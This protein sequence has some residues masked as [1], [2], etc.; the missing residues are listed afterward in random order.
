MSDSVR[1]ASLRGFDELV[2]SLGGDPLALLRSQRL[3]AA[4]LVDEELLLPAHNLT[5]LLQASAR[6]LGCADFGLRLAQAQDIGILGP[7]AVAIQNAPTLGEAMRIASRYLYVHNQ[8]LAITLVP[9]GRAV[10]G[11]AELRYEMPAIYLPA[12]HQSFE[13]MLC[14]G[15]RFLAALGGDHYRLEAVH[16]P[17]APLATPAAYR[18]AFGLMPHFNQPTASLVVPRRLFDAP[19]RQANPTLRNLATHYLE[20]NFIAPRQSLLA[21]VRLALTRTLGTSQC[22]LEGVAAV[23]AMHPRT[24][25][26]QLSAEGVR[27]SE[28]HDAVLREAALRYLA[29]TMPLAQVSAQLGL[30]EQSALTRSCKRWFGETPLAVRR[31]TSG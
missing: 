31:R 22:G 10:A 23:L 18:R 3:P 7:V 14:G 26:R 25:Q 28:V 30:S 27:F 12:S 8:G 9:D 5:R 15:H 19:L 2:R 16:L 6:V 24:L 1:A 4:A 29:G 11:L 21:R 20:S 13:L 17:H